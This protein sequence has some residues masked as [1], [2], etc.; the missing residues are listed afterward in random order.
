MTDKYIL[1]KDGNPIICNDLILWGKWMAK[2]DDA[3]RIALDYIDEVKIST[4]FLGL[5]HQFTHGSPLLYETMI[6]G[7]EHDGYQDRYSTR[8]EALFGH[9]KAL[10]MVKK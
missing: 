5:D 6:F 8:N 4:V 10:D 2:N 9:N 1:D 3:R 7:G